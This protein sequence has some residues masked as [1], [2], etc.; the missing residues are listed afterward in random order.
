MWYLSRPSAVTGSMPSMDFAAA[1][2]GVP[3]AVAK[4]AA[5]AAAKAKAAAE[6]E[7]GE[8]AADAHGKATKQILP[9]VPD[10]CCQCEICCWC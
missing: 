8:P 7:G 4:A 10:W 3:T 9:T 1:P 6:K 2:N 5:K